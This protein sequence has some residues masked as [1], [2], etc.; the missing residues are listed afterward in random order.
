MLVRKLKALILGAEIRCIRSRSTFPGFFVPLGFYPGFSYRATYHRCIFCR[1]FLVSCYANFFTYVT[2]PALKFFDY[3]YLYNTF[4]VNRLL[5]TILAHWCSCIV[6]TVS[7]ARSQCETSCKTMLVNKPLVLS[8]RGHHARVTHQIM[9]LVLSS[10][11]ARGA[12]GSNE[13]ANYEH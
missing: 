12:K 9:L 1:F 4:P 13:V 6:N 2:A 11:G 3:G 8:V 10:A 5:S 7:Q